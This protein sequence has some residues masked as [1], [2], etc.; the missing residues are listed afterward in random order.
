MN[1]H[2]HHELINQTDQMAIMALQKDSS[3]LSEII[4]IRPPLKMNSFSG[5]KITQLRSF[6]FMTFKNH[7]ITKLDIFLTGNET[8]MKSK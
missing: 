1:T 5:C 8:I 4:A 2:N 6:Y 3:F 7:F